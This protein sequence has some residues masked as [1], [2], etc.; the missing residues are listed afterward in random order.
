[1]KTKKLYM[2]PSIEVI[3]IETSDIIATSGDPM[4]PVFMPFDPTQ[5]FEGIA[6]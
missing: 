5:E 1:M 2:M 6:D 4:A 3:Q